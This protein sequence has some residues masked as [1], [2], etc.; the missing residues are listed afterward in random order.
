MDA[1]IQLLCGALGSVGFAMIFR[2]RPAFLPLAALGGL[3]NWGSYLL[4]FHLTDA[5]F[6]SCLAA[7]AL[8]AIYAELLAKHL[9]APTTVF[10]VPTVIPSIPGS[11]LYY[12]MSAAVAGN[13]RSTAANALLTAEYAFGIAAGISIVWVFFA[14]I[15]SSRLHK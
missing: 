6:L 15:S 10:L 9:R 8:S 12:T 13:W 4:L 1:L 2:M 11:N 14:M 3:I 7:S 5:L